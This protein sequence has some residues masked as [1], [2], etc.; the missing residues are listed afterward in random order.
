MRGFYAFTFA[1]TDFV[2]FRVGF[3]ILLFYFRAPSISSFS[4]SEPLR[5]FASSK[6]P[7]NREKA[8]IFKKIKAALLYFPGFGFK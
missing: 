4:N 7:K 1:R 3:W 8:V 2:F 5:K 6:R